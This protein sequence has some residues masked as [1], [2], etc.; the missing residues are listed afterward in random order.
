M[1]VGARDQFSIAQVQELTGLTPRTV[2]FYISEGLIP[3]AHGRGPSATYDQSQVLRLQ[4]IQQW[5]S[6]RLP[7]EEIKT[8]LNRLSDR[9]VVSIVRAESQPVGETWRRIALHPDIELHVRSRSMPEGSDLE[10]TVSVILD[11]VRPLIERMNRR[12]N[13]R[14][15]GRP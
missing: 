8:R 1:T 13:G 15:P 11:Q 10:E 4:L 12:Q 14:T 7:L 3:P 5:K 2:R 6:E 9:E